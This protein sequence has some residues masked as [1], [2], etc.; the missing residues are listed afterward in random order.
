MCGIVGLWMPERRGDPDA[1]EAMVTAMADRVA[2]RGP[3]AS[4]SWLD[5]DLGLALGHRQLAV[6]GL[7]ETGA[8]PMLRTTGAWSFSTVPGQ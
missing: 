7:G 3:D 2:H 6:V 5:A 8:Q 1:L 4:G